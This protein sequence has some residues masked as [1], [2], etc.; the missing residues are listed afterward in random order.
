MYST[1]RFWEVCAL[2]WGFLLCAF[3]VLVLFE[4]FSL[5]S[6]SDAAF[7]SWSYVNGLN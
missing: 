7:S 2:W 1:S 4:F 5:L 6:S 3:V